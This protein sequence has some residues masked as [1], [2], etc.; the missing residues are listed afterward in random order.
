MS[1]DI[2]DL[3]AGLWEAIGVKTTIL[4]EDYGS[5][6]SARFRERTQIWPTLKNGAV[7]DANLARPLAPAFG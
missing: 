2:G 7:D 4:N 1:F 6:V 3:T 5:V